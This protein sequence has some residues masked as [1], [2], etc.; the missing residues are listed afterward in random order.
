MPTRDPD[1]LRLPDRSHLGPGLRGSL[2]LFRQPFV[3]WP[4]I[5]GCAA[6]LAG[7]LA[8][9]VNNERAS[10]QTMAP[11]VLMTPLIGFGFAVLTGLP[12]FMVQ[13]AVTEAAPRL[14]LEP[15]EDTLLERRANHFLGDEARG[16]RLFVTTRRL[17]FVPHRFNVQLAMAEIALDRVEAA[18]WARIVGAYGAQLSSIVEVAT[19]GGPQT[20]V[21]D[22][23]EG[24]ARLVDA[25]RRAEPGERSAK[26]RALAE[27]LAG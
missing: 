23:A 21:V 14:E 3:L 25:L 22:R 19:A 12:G 6:C 7:L 8:L 11:L 1:A 2:F 10:F 9:S 5:A 27:E 16:G 15:G 13:R 18:R 26:G 17:V 24:I 20:F 4:A